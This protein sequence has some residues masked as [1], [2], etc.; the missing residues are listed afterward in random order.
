MLVSG[1]LISEILEGVFTMTGSFCVKFEVSIKKVRSRKATS[2]IAVISIAVLLR[3]S[4]TFA[5]IY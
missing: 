1:I 5:I 3:G 2:H 4:L